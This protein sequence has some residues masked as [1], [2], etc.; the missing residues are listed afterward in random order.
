MTGDDPNT[1]GTELGWYGFC[2]LLLDE[3]TASSKTGTPT[4]TQPVYTI[5]SGHAAS[6]YTPTQL[7]QG[8]NDMVDSDDPA[9][10]DGLTT[11]GQ[12]DVDQNTA[13]PGSES[14][15]NAGY[16]FGFA[17][18]DL[19]DLPD[20][21]NTTKASNGA[22]HLVTSSLYLGACVD[23][24]TNGQPSGTAVGDN[25]AASDLTL[26]GSAH[27]V[28]QGTCASAGN[29]E[30]GVTLVTPMVAGSQACVAVTAVNGT[31]GAANLYG[32]IDFNNNGS[33]DASEALTAGAGGTAATSPP[34]RRR[35]TP[36]A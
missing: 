33:F 23:A 21:Y 3:D 27:P 28:T 15:P 20:N 17:P 10:V 1:G 30:E 4:A 11:Q 26:N 7:N 19:G 32:W 16:D 6:G 18:A 25:N 9:G 24:E 12:T 31:G 29:D 34:A 5:T 35:S 36:A 8:G 13:A 2:N 14:N 22:L